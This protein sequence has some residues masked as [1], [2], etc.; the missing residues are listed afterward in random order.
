MNARYK[1][2]LIILMTLLYSGP[3]IAAKDDK[4]GPQVLISPPVN[5]SQYTCSYTN[6]TDADL[7]V[8][9]SVWYGGG[10]WTGGTSRVLQP[11]NPESLVGGVV[12][13]LFAVFCMVEWEGQKGDVIASFC[14]NTQ[15]SSDRYSCIELD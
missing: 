1:L 14:G 5:W 10:V 9:P 2:S 12:D 8:T 3:G 11:M 4:S 7:T 6:L 13:D 15:S